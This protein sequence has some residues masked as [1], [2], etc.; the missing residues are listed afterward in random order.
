MTKV[1]L[2]GRV[3]TSF[4]RVHWALRRLP[5]PQAVQSV[6]ESP[7][8]WWGSLAP[9]RLSRTVDRV[10]RIGPWRP[11]CLIGSLVLY[12]LLRAQGTQA[13]VVIGLPDRPEEIGAHAW[14]EVDRIDVGPSPGRGVHEELVRYP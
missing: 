6:G 4:V 1:R 12:R 11:R 3:W 5:L 9:R 10:L 7:L 8:A 13:T 2:A 14:I